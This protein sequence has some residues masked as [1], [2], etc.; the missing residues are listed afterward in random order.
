[1]AVRPNSDDVTAEVASDKVI[2]GRPGGLTL[3]S[4]EVGAARAPTAARPIFDV[5]EWR[6]NQ[7]ENFTARLDA[8]VAA[9][10]AAEPDPRAPAR[11]DLARFYMSRGMYHEA[12]AVLDLAMADAKP[13]AEDPVVLIVH[14]VASILIG[15]PGQGLKD[16]ANPAIGSNYDS[17][18]W[19]A[20]AYVRQ[21]KWADAREKFKNAEFAI[22]SLPIDLQRIVVSEAMR[23]SLEVKDY[24]GAAKRGERSGSHRRAARIEARDVGAARPA[25]RSARPRQGCAGRIQDRRGTRRIA[26]PP[27]KPSCSRSRCGRSATRSARPTPCA[28]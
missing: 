15:R 22:T 4:A 3:S 25:R 6:K 21:G 2:L 11:I 16:L 9:A 28:N 19:K 14:A 1:M 12:R 20:L 24:S 10:S 5:A 26:P 7:E 23:A 18:L 13:G 27:P 17:Q 8:L